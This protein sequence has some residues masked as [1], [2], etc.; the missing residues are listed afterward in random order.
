MIYIGGDNFTELYKAAPEAVRLK[1]INNFAFTKEQAKIV[2]NENLIMYKSEDEAIKTKF[3]DIFSIKECTTE[4]LFKSSLYSQNKNMISR[5][6]N[7]TKEQVDTWFSSSFFIYQRL[8]YKTCV[9]LFKTGFLSNVQSSF[10]FNRELSGYSRQKISIIEQAIKYNVKFSDTDMMS[11]II[12]NMYDFE[13]SSFFS[14]EDLVNRFL[15]ECFRMCK[16][17]DGFYYNFYRYDRCSWILS[18]LPQNYKMWSDILKQVDERYG[19]YKDPIKLALLDSLEKGIISQEFL[20]E[21]NWDDIIP[22]SGKIL[23]NL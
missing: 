23:H 6:K 22:E 15:K 10:L 13:F 11:H 16:R 9:H 1:V 21:I 8:S 19:E 5:I 2:K 4:I 7:L 17:D 18:H 12:E 14:Q 3:P 20:E